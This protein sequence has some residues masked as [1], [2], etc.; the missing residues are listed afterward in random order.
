MRKLFAYNACFDKKHLPEYSGY[1]WYD[2]MRLAA[3]RQYNRAIRDSADCCKTGKL[4]RGY[5]VENIFRMLSKNDGYNEMHNSLLDAQDELKIME[6]LGCEIREYDIAV[7]EKKTLVSKLP[8]RENIVEGEI[9]NLNKNSYFQ[10][11][12]GKKKLNIEMTFLNNAFMWKSI[13]SIPI[14]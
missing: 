1:E 2:I 13:Y 4:K 11:F 7:L 12:R 14:I 9:N 8:E 10:N 6:L 3:Y 5:G